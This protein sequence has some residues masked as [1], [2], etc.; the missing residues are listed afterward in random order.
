LAPIRNPD[1][2]VEIKNSNLKMKKMNVRIALFTMVL[3]S[4]VQTVTAQ[5]V[6]WGVK[7]GF[8]M[9]TLKA[10]YPSEKYSPGFHIG[11]IADFKISDKFSIQPELFYS[12]EGGKLNFAFVMDFE[13][14]G[15]MTMKI[16]EDIK[17]G[18][19]QL[20]VMMKYMVADKL[21]VEFGPQIGYLIHGKNNYDIQF[22][23]PDS[24]ED[25]SESMDMKEVMK[26]VNY[27]LNFGI[28]YE[29]KNNIF[30][31]GRYHLGLSDNSKNKSSSEEE[32]YEFS[33]SVKNRG[34]QLSI[35]Y[36]F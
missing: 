31:Q 23:T 9:S 7:G 8:N 2:I 10:G 27:G 24:S 30:F 5:E 26:S 33:S 15:S 13:E 4:M 19:L 11:G 28:G 32:D 3:L 16:N 34:F 35:G 6:K 12:L 20:P 1:T 21:S 25:F 17:L 22:I 36:R 14:M 29:L 18:Y